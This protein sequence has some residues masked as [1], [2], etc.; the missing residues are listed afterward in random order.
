MKASSIAL[1]LVYAVGS[2]HLALAFS[3]EPSK[4][5]AVTQRAAGLPDQFRAAFCGDRAGTPRE[6]SASHELSGDYSRA[7]LAEIRRREL[8]TRQT[9]QEALASMTQEYCAPNGASQ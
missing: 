1:A 9:T 2:W 4:P 6:K 5:S 8:K 3:S 7:L